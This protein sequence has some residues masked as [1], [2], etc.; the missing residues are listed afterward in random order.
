MNKFINPRG[1]PIPINWMA[2]KPSPARFSEFAKTIMLLA[3]PK[4][5]KFPAIEAPAASAIMLV[6]C[7]PAVFKTGK[8]SATSGTFEI[9]WLPTTDTKNTDKV[10]FTGICEA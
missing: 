6:A 5:R 7:A 1:I 3:A 8:Y 4:M 9:S 10:C 2:V